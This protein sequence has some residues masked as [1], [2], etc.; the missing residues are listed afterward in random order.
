M[1]E[2][3]QAAYNEYYEKYKRNPDYIALSSQLLLDW[4]VTESFPGSKPTLMGMQILVIN[5]YGLGFDLYEKLELDYAL[6]EYEKNYP[7]IKDYFAL[8]VNHIEARR[9]SS[10]SNEKLVPQD[11]GV[12]VHID[13]R[14]ACAYKQFVE[15]IKNNQANFSN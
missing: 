14:V 15:N 8:R 7:Q 2:K 6:G 4:P 10:N 5:D 12:M 3:I 1:L 11:L 13:H 9:I